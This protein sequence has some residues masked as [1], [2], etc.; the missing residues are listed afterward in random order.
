[1]GVRLPPGGHARR[2]D[3][4]VNQDLFDAIESPDFAAA[5]G[6]ASAAGALLRNLVERP[7]VIGLVEAS[8]SR[9]VAREILY[10]LFDL[11]A[12]DPDVRY[13][14][15]HDVAVCAYLYC[16]SRAEDEALFNEAACYTSAMANV[17][18]HPA[19][20]WAPVVANMLQ[21]QHVT[22]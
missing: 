15:P 9:D 14:S 10:R 1:M 18:L 7:E 4:G 11:S 6:T 17:Q 3:G 21:H 22:R 2:G 12:Y 13:Y 16:L 20:W 19:F 8:R 5:V